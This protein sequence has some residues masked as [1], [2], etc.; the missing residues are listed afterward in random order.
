MSYDSPKVTIYPGNVE[1]DNVWQ[2]V[3]ISIV[4]DFSGSMFEYSPLLPE[5]WRTLVDFLHERPADRISVELACCPFSTD[6]YFHTHAPTV[7]YKGK[8]LTFDKMGFTSLGTALRTVIE[9]TR[10]RRQMLASEG[11]DSLRAVCVVITDGGATDR[12]ALDKAIEEMRICEAEGEMEFVPVTPKA[13]SVE[14]L[15]FIFGKEAIPFNGLDF[16][17][18]FPALAASVSQ[19]SQSTVGRE[20]A[21]GRLLDNK[22]RLNDV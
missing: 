19:Y 14:L 1:F 7:F 20:P 16:A 18:V 22:L 5:C 9:H 3:L 10:H 2:R 13:D 4:L 6:I 8:S 11:I 21:M 15:H 17:A 12:P